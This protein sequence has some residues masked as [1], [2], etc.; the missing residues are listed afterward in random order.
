MVQIKRN[1]GRRPKPHLTIALDCGM[2]TRPQGQSYGGLR[3]LTYNLL[4]ELASLDHRNRYFL[5]S[6]HPLLHVMNDFSKNM[7]N[8][9]LPRLGFKA[10]WMP[11]ALLRDKPD[12]FLATAQ[13]RPS[14]VI[15]TVGF[16]YDVAFI[17]NPHLYEDSKRLKNNTEQLVYNARH[18]ITISNSSKKDIVDVFKVRD[19]FVTCAIP[20][21]AKIFTPRGSKYMDSYPYFLYVGTLRKTKNI[22][23]LVSCFSKFIKRAKNK[24]MLVLITPTVPENALLKLI[25]R[26]GMGEYIRFMHNVDDKELPKYYRGALAFV[27]F[28]TYEGFGLPFVEAMACGTPV[29]TTNFSS[30]P[31]IVDGS[32]YLVKLN[33]VDKAVETLLR[34]AYDAPTR[35]KMSKK[36]I[37]Q[38][39]HF[40]LRTFA[41]TVLDT[42]YR[43]EKFNDHNEQIA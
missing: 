26:L 6:Y 28:T 8:H 32:G 5:Y 35:Q 9:L 14:T 30:A 29:I 22:P 34:L 2:F 10:I 24:F 31:E 37:R 20:G 12:V 1:V 42:V 19:D 18:I 3:T 17:K 16:V 40:N 11:L 41:R 21:V 33:D 36:A 39:R 38:S 15:P 25:N 4:T 23:F 27:S 43:I 13:A 7:E